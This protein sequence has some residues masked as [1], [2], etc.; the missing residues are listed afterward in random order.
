MF[1]RA[2]RTAGPHL[3]VLAAGEGDELFRLRHVMVELGDAVRHLDRGKP[4]RN[5]D[6]PSRTVFHARSV[7]RTRECGPRP[8][9][10]DR[11]CST[12]TAG[13]ASGKRVRKW[14]R[15]PARW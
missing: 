2:D 3:R 1:D 8:A 5:V 4:V 12:F 15:R 10:F 7:P 9:E 11:P 14:A 13:T 6:T